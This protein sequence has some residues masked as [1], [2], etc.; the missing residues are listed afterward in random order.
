MR[1][2]PPSPITALV[3]ETPQYDLG[4]SYCRELT[5]G[6]LLSADEIAAL[7]QVP[8]GYGSSA[9]APELRQLI[10]DRSGVT[11]DEVLL[12]TG[13]ASSL[14]L[15]GLL[16][17][18]ADSEIVVVRPSFPPMFDALRGI[19]A[20]IA[21][22]QLRFADGYRLDPTVLRDALSANT[23]LVML[24][25]PHSPS[26]V[27]MS[28][29]DIEQTLAVIEQVC[30]DAYLLVDEIYREATHG[31]APVPP[32]S[33]ALSPKVITCSSLSKA[34]GAPGLRIGWMT[35]RDTDLYGQLRLARFNSAVSC[36]TLDEVL[37]ARVLQ[38]A[39]SIL[40]PRRTLLAD[41]LAVVEDWLATQ[42]G[43]LRW[44]RPD[45]GAFCCVE[46]DPDAFPAARVE[47]FYA[48]LSERSTAVAP[49][50][51]FGDDRRVFRLG[52]GYEP[53]DKLGAGLDVITQALR[54]SERMSQPEV[55]GRRADLV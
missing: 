18:D 33:A 7:S 30:P 12:T 24:A 13:A 26:G 9:G 15:L 21:T 25:S 16:F 44:V 6:D 4:E 11:P 50:E 29:E 38:R 52:F 37:A 14:F 22:V 40:A 43:D 48:E 41:A 45:A 51:W 47:R 42:Q 1:R 10:A 39:E 19:N 49:G 32:S 2:F 20:R 28:R 55:A 27:V 36:G 46:L 31:Q 3:D 23:R 8:L 5:L 17:G 35:V 54:A 34:H 53:L